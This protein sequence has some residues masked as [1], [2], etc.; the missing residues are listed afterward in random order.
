VKE[1]IIFSEHKQKISSF[2]EMETAP[3]PEEQGKMLKESTK[4]ALV[5]LET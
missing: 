2:L 4:A 1:K 5:S 3:N